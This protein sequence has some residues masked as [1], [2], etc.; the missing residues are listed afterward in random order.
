VDPDSLRLTVAGTLVTATFD[1]I[2]GLLWYSPTVAFANGVYTL[3]IQAADTTGNA[4]TVTSPFTIAVPAPAVGGVSP[5]VI[6]QGITT[7]VA[8]TGTGFYPGLALYIG[9]YTPPSVAYFSAAMLS[10]TMAPTSPLGIH[11][12]T[13]TNPDGLS[14]TLID[15]LIV[16]IASDVNGDCVVGMADI[17]LVANRWRTSCENPDPD[18]NLNTPSYDAHYDLDHDCD[19]DIVD[20]M[21]VAVHWGETCP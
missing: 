6:Y 2:Q 7:T 17:M 8:I 1:P 9:D 18:N 19:I 12:V 16:T 15:G 4:I 20:I 11:A 13:V 21:L 5:N 3:S 14:G 10:V